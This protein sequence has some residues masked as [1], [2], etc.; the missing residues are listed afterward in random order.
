MLFPLEHRQVVGGEEGWLPFLVQI[1]EVVGLWQLSTSSW[2]S[3][4]ELRQ[5]ERKC[6]VD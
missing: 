6:Y 4:G 2:V 3:G 5:L 1:G